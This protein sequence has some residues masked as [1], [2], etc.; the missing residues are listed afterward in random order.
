MELSSKTV[1]NGAA[2]VGTLTTTATT[3]RHLALWRHCRLS[4]FCRLFS[5][6]K[7]ETQRCF[8][9]ESQ[10]VHGCVWRSGSRSDNKCR[11]NSWH[12]AARLG[13]LGGP[14]WSRT[15]WAAAQKLRS[16]WSWRHPCFPQSRD[17]ETGPPSQ[18]AAG[19]WR[20]PRPCCPRRWTFS[21]GCSPAS[22]VWNGSGWD[23]RSCFWL[24]TRKLWWL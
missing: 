16:W 14:S 1:S 22:I 10:H 18:R 15:G 13:S 2:V 24:Q 12:Q 17:V 5:R 11:W 4:S 19:W 3:T 6:Q 23:C 20:R 9:S 21:M 7:A 8:S